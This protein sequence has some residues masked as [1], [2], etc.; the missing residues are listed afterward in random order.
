MVE[1]KTGHVICLL[2][3]RACA[4]QCPR[5][6]LP[7]YSERRSSLTTFN[8]IAAVTLIFSPNSLILLLTY[9]SV[10]SLAQIMPKEFFSMMPVSRSRTR[11]QSGPRPKRSAASAIV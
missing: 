1:L 3:H 2:A 10:H 9:S 7:P 8:L 6:A 4:N 5:L 11:N